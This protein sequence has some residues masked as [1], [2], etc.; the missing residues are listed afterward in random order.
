MCGDAVRHCPQNSLC[1]LSACCKVAPIILLSTATWTAGVPAAEPADLV[2]TDAKVVTIDDRQPDA[3]A[4]AIKGDRIVAVTTGAGISP[5][6]GPKTR[7]MALDGRLVLPGF[8]EGHG[9]FLGLGQAKMILDLT[10]A[11]SWDEIVQQVA[12]ASRK[13]PAGTWILGRGW[14]QSKW[15]KKPQ[16]SVEGNPT[17]EA[18]SERTPD[19]PVLLTHASGHMCI[20]NALALRMAGLNGATPSPP[21]GEILRDADG[22]LTGVLRE[23]ATEL[24]ERVVERQQRDRSPQQK[25]EDLL[26]SVR[27]AAEEC[28]RHGV[29]SFQDAGASFALV[30][31]YKALVEQG[32][33]PVRLWVML[34]EDNDSLAG[35]LE[36]YFLVGCGNQHLTVRAIKRLVDGALGSHGAWMLEPYEDL[37]TSCGL[38]TL[39]LESLRA[40]AALAI[41]HGYQLCVHAI[42]DRANRE[43]LNV[44]QQTFEAHPTRRDLRWRVEHAQHLH[45][46]DIPRFAQLGV[47]A[48]MQAVH[49]T[50]DGPYVVTRLGQRRSQEGAYA[51]KSLREAG[52]IISNGTDVPV[53]RVDPMAGIY[54]AVTRKMSNGEPFF[55]EQCMT[56]QQALRSY[57]LDAAYAA[58]E[59]NLK[60]SITVGKL[61]DLVVL[62]DDILTIPE[63]R[64]PETEVVCTIVG[65][66]VVFSLVQ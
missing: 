26:A 41:D 63:E 24:V 14:H 1:R 6:I 36:D 40:T 50:S 11:D 42:G 38:N 44:Y 59:E 53:E 51:W 45:P 57:T 30:D 7:V 43:V 46:A 19:H 32:Q 47:I 60:G 12:E 9:H 35:K 37:P 16:P 10:T 8:I 2:L 64:I 48:S 31:S 49:A 25:H 15:S 52:A 62:S 23:T 27:L 61:A 5:W 18:L 28:L 4:I 3:E 65:G 17:H 21:G 33:L 66:K 58:F 34:H 54:S 55:P 29:T 39:P 20:V 56:R 13:A 22:R